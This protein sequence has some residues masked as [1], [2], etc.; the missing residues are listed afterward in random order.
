MYWNLLCA[1]LFACCCAFAEV[2]EHDDDDEDDDVGDVED[3]DDAPKGIIVF[4][5]TICICVDDK[6]I[7]YCLLSDLNETSVKLV[8]ETH[9]SQAFAFLIAF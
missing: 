2:N 1:S 7:F 4:V 3:E 6:I 8:Y 5:F 9:C